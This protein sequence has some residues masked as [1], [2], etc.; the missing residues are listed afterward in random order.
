MSLIRRLAL[1]ATPRRGLHL[2]L[3]RS[4]GAGAAHHKPPPAHGTGTT[5]ESSGNWATEPLGRGKSKVFVS[6]DVYVYGHGG[7][8]DWT[9]PKYAFLISIFFFF[10]WL[11]FKYMQIAHRDIIGK[12][13]PH[14]VRG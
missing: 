4:F 2:A 10:W 7:G 1:R 5:C 13:N 14:P 6:G 3:G 8:H 12:P 11:N 9:A